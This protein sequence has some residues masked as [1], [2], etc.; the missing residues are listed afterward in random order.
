MAFTHADISSPNCHTQLQRKVLL[1][2]ELF[3]LLLLV[4]D[5]CLE[6]FKLLTDT[7]AIVV[8]EWKPG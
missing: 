6:S 5:H 3:D 8:V 1:H 2:V 7:L 4:R